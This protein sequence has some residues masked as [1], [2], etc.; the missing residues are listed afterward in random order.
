MT[1]QRKIQLLELVKQYLTDYAYYGICETFAILESRNPVNCTSE[2]L[3]SL[4]HFIYDN[5]PSKDN[6]YA[7]FMDYETWLGKRF[8]WERITDAPQTRK[9]R[10][11]FI[12]KLIENIN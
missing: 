6:Q 4:Q 5:K 3:N 2:E 11:D 12:T 10:I 7:Y 1:N 9:I 8:W